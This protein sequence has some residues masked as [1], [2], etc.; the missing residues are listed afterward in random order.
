[1][2]AETLLSPFFAG[3]AVKN[4]DALRAEYGTEAVSKAKHALNEAAAKGSV[5]MFPLTRPSASTEPLPNAGE[6]AFE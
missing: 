3:G 4:T 2:L 6:C 5:E 1:M